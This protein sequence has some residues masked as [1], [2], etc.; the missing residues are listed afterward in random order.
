[1]LWVYD[2]HLN[3]FSLTAQGSDLNIR[4]QIRTSKVDPRAVRVKN[5]MKVKVL[6]IYFPN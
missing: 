5:H 6:I 3:M 1:M 4:R 2:H